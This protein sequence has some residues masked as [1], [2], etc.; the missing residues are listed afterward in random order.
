[1]QKLTDDLITYLFSNHLL[2]IIDK[3]HFSM[4]C[5][6]HRKLTKDLLYEF[7]KEFKYYDFICES[8]NPIIEKETLEIL[9]CGY[10][11]LLTDKHINENNNVLVKGC[12]MFGNVKLLEEIKNIPKFEYDL[13]NV[14][15]FA[16]RSN[17]D[18]VIK[19]AIENKL[20]IRY[21]TYINTINNGNLQILKILYENDKNSTI[22]CNISEIR[23]FVIEK[24]Q[25]E[26]YN[27][28]CM[29]GYNCDR[30]NHIKDQCALL[31]ALLLPTC[32]VFKPKDYEMEIGNSY[33]GV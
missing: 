24:G 23:E 19:W 14:T 6:H 20:S 5:K 13:E 10:F 27:W 4:L 15:I 29:I 3:R 16:A 22:D 33:C 28:L 25:Y 18:N 8:K 9:S 17:Q 30:T 7:D 26:I 12:A 1:M 11:H 2:L 21:E 32:I 31:K